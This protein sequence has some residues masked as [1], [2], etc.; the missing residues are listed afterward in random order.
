MKYETI[1]GCGELGIEFSNVEGDGARVT[2]DFLRELLKNIVKRST[3]YYEETGEHAFTYRERQL[4]SVVCPSIADITSSYLMENPLTR[5]PA[6]EEEYRGSVDYWISYKNYSFLMELKHTF[7]AYRNADNPRE[8]ITKKFVSAIEQLKNIRKDECRALTINNKGLIKI[9][10]LTVV[11]YK[12][13]KDANL[14]EDLKHRDF[15][16][17]FRKLVNNTELKHRSNLRSLWVLHE[18]LVEPVDYRN[19]SEI[20]PAVAFVGYISEMIE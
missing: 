12:G 10:L 17:L 1:R 9:A 3:K 16:S 19:L 2:K 20:Y 11:F 6:G 7:F 13:S 8:S 14:K 15:K 18:R 5:K 4:H